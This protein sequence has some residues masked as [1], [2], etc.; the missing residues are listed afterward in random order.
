M[1][2]TVM[3]SVSKIVYFISTYTLVSAKGVVKLFLHHVWKLY[4]LS[5]H[6]VSN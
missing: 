6:V 1:I 4:S 2:M 3:D 5:T